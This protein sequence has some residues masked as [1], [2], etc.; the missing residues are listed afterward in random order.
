M[1]CMNATTELDANPYN[2]GTMETKMCFFNLKS[3]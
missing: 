3:S 2:T 1:W